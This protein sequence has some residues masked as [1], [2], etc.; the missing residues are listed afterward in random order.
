MNTVL[1]CGAGNCGVWAVFG[2]HKHCL[3]EVPSEK[4]LQSNLDLQQRKGD[5]YTVK[6]LAKVTSNP[7]G[8]LNPS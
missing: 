7:L 5:Y 1:L 2:A 6:N 3:K 4:D 8:Y